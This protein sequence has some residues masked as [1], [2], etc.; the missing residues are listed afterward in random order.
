MAFIKFNDKNAMVQADVQPVSEHIIRILGSPWVDTSG[1]CLYMDKDKAY[2]LDHGEYEEYK[3]LYRQGDSWYE[4]SDDGSEYVEPGEVSDVL[5]G[6]LTEGL[7]TE[8]GQRVKLAKLN[9]LI[10]Q[11]KAEL[12]ATDYQIIK[13]YEF[14]LVD[15]DTGYD[16]QQLHKERQAIRDQIN[17]LEGQVAELAKTE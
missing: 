11:Y 12:A 16:I 10:Q 1:F 9:F 7:L 6:E 15:K 17:D 4:L 14:S 2:P 5:M 8:N 3:T 13:A